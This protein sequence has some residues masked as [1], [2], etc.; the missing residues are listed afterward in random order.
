[1]LMKI[2][3]ILNLQGSL[4]EFL[5]TILEHVKNTNVKR[6][7]EIRRPRWPYQNEQVLMDHPVL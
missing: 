5:E 2:A 3:E 1:M 4:G 7:I 6:K